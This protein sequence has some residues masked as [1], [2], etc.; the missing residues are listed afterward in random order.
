[1][2]L[3]WNFKFHT[4]K[5]IPFLLALAIAPITMCFSQTEPNTK[6][7]RIQI[8][9]IEFSRMSYFGESSL[10]T[11]QDFQNLALNNN[12]P[13]ID[14]T[15]LQSMGYPFGS[16]LNGFNAALGFDLYNK[17]GVQPWGKPILRLGLSFMNSD[18]NSL[19]YY[20]QDRFAYDT[21]YTTFQG[22]TSAFPV[23]SVA[24]QYKSISAS[25]NRLRLNASVLWRT[26]PEKRW[27]FYAGIGLGIGVSLSSKINVYDY[28]GSSLEYQSSY[29]TSSM[30]GMYKSP[31][32]FGSYES[33]RGRTWFDM[34]VFMPIG[35]DFRIG[36]KDNMWYHTHLFFEASPMI[37]LSKASGVQIQT[38]MGYSGTFGL[39]I[40]F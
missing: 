3:V 30:Q 28:Q 9:S 39:R 15:G 18:F 26:N 21:L 24:Y 36:K 37:W 13:E 20:R 19:N 17:S 34:N 4:M 29:G 38:N 12:L 31:M 35:V 33:I 27:S 14:F 6:L 32:G 23:D 10:M 25:A 22:N 7:R 5:K 16:R 11:V 2:R 8:S 1:M 40:K